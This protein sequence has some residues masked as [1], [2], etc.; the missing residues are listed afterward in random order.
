LIV[1]WRRNR[2]LGLAFTLLLA[3]HAAMT[4][5]YFNIPAN[6]FRPFDRHYLPVFVTLGVL[7][8]CGLSVVTQQTG[9]VATSRRRVG[10]AIG[11]LAAVLTPAAQLFG[12]WTSHDA[13][14]R[15]F[16]RDFAANAL[17][18]LPPNA[19]YF[20]V[21]DNDTFPVMY[22]QTVEGVRPDV[23]IVNLS[24]ANAAWYVD[25]LAKRDVT[26]PVTRSADGRRLTSISSDTTVVIPVR[27]T[28]LRLGLPA[29]SSIPASV[30]VRPRPM[31]GTEATAAD[32]VLLDI[33]RTN[34][35]RDP[36]TFA[37]TGGDGGTP[38]LLPYARLEGLHWRVV[39]VAD[40]GPDRDTLR[41]NLLERFQFRGYSEPSITIDDTTRIMGSLYVRAFTAL[42]DAEKAH[43]AIERCREA[44][45]SLMT[46]LPPERLAFPGNDREK[47]EARCGG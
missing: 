5:L 1:L 33:V 22:L 36:I 44:A 3:I 18:S 21:G 45:T 26:F 10:V 40:L 42:L 12:N 6:Y 47:I 13:S 17:Q 7:V 8:A 31:F 24:L 11:V 25:Q 9:N 37:I 16:T 2:R 30:T 27:S 38:W 39:P 32:S 19:I 14:E 41:T 15:Y 20:T 34:A 4:V 46:I 35:W 28:A 23:R 43:G 29:D